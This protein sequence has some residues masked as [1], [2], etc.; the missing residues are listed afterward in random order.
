MSLEKSSILYKLNR[1]G[2]LKTIF[3]KTGNDFYFALSLTLIYAIL[4]I[5]FPK[6]SV[7]WQS[8]IA[9]AFLGSLLA[10]EIAS[11]V[12]I[13]N[14]QN[15][16]HS[17]EEFS[18][19]LEKKDLLSLVDFYFDFTFIILCISFMVW[20]LIAIAYL[21]F[22]AFSLYDIT[23][24]GMENSIIFSYLF[25]LPLFFFLF[26]LGNLFNC[27]KARGYYKNLESK[28]LNKKKQ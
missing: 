21:I 15:E 18:L 1:V 20:I 28:F 25:I 11:I 26:F 27:W 16:V 12:I 8:T 3:G 19:Y 5:Y 23:F 10:I 17:K 13:S 7:F 22:F 2:G 9:F 6:V 24:F 4:I 14:W